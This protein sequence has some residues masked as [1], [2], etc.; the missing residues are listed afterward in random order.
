MLAHP[1]L[2][3]CLITHPELQLLHGFQAPGAAAPRTVSNAHPQPPGLPL[4]SHL[5]EWMGKQ[6]DVTQVDDPEG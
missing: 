3:F 1:S 6:V 5:P 4:F 2:H